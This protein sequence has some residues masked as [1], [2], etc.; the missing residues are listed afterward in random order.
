MISIILGLI[1]LATGTLLIAT[2]SSFKDL[3]LNE[4]K[5]R[6]R[7]G[8]VRVRKIYQVLIYGKQL[9]LFLW[10]IIGILTSTSLIVLIGPIPSWLIVILFGLY[11]CFSYGYLY[12]KKTKIGIF[13]VKMLASFL[14][15]TLDILQPVL[16]YIVPISST[17]NLQQKIYDAEDL[18]SFIDSQKKLAHN[19]IDA[20]EL[21]NLINSLMFNHSMIHNFMNQIEKMITV[22]VLDSI[23]PVLME[24][25]HGSNRRFFPV[26]SNKKNNIVGSLDLEKI[27]NIKKGGLVKDYVDNNIF[28]L[29][30]DNT[31]LDVL[32]AIIKTN[33]NFFFVID[34]KANVVGFISAEDVFNQIINLVDDDNQLEYRDKIEISKQFHE[35]T[36]EKNDTE[37]IE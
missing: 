13:L 16:S 31:L 18:L 35:K 8:G 37:V 25:L 1:F 17:N 15:K 34:D 6:A 9:D 21:D 11:A 19:R 4:Y 36:L 23:G 14:A 32:K 27:L 29:H 22:N 26:Y 12:Q 33:N 2:L 30:T 5:R 10:L 3:S 20:K 7:S 24:E 28:Y